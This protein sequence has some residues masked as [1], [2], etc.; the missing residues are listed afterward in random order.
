MYARCINFVSFNDFETIR[1]AKFQ[2]IQGAN[3][4]PS[5]EEEQTTQWLK[6]NRQTM[7]YKTLYRKLKIEQHESH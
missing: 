7:T 3:Q 5:I 2:D 6:E 4:K 1:R